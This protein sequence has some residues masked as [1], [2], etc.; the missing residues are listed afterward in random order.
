MG[1]SSRKDGASVV[2]GEASHILSLAEWEYQG[3]GVGEAPTGVGVGDPQGSL[4][5]LAS[6]GVSGES[7]DRKGDCLFPWSGLS[8]GTGQ[9]RP[10]PC[11]VV[12]VYFS[13][14]FLGP[15]Q[16]SS[17]HTELQTVQRQPQR[18]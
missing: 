14:S 1:A 12:S 10:L 4:V 11:G 17:S 8:W 7:S 9:R 15:T 6:V 5:F 16:S 3:P 18:R 2:A 13:L